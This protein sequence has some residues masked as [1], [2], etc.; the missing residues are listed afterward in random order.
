MVLALLTA[1]MAAHLALRPA[2]L[3]AQSSASAP[4]GAEHTGAAFTFVPIVD[5]VYHA[6]GT[7]T[8]AVG[9]NAGI[10]V[11][12]DGVVV[13]DALVSPAAAYVLVQEL[14]ALTHKP[15]R[16]VITTHFHYDHAH[17]MQAFGPGVELVAHEFTRAQLLAGASQRGAA[18][19][20]LVRVLGERRD[21]LQR[22][23]GQ[24]RDSAARAPLREALE[25]VRRYRV[26]AIDD[27]RPTPPTVTFRD[28]LRLYRGGREIRVLH[29]GPA[30]TGGD[31]V[32]FLPKERV[33]FT[34]D[35]V[36]ESLPYLGDG[37]L[38]AWGE[39]LD[40]IRALGATVVLPGHGAA[41]RDVTVL[42]HEAALLRDL[43]RQ[44]RALLAAGVPVE[45]VEPRL[46]L[47]AHVAHYPA[48]LGDRRNPALTERLAIGVARIAQ[49][50]AAEGGTR[51]AP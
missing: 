27:V 33:V 3:P 12:D 30:H 25:R 2:P 48:V 34:G 22:L 49:L 41:I 29:W 17:G 10:I 38:S 42:E 8:L 40:R 19:E 13:V 47:S 9:S 14:R 24:A 46:D 35:L 43:D 1:G 44:A 23:L 6:V 31:A 20:G 5:G 37:Q 51:K 18:Y 11:T 7:G 21:S 28:E 15:V 36:S 26:A 50:R 4:P 45:Q 39:V 32:V 16:T